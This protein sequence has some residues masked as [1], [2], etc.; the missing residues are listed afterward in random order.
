MNTTALPSALEVEALSTLVN[1]TPI[2]SSSYE[3]NIERQQRMGN[4]Y[5]CVVCGKDSDFK[6]AVNCVEGDTVEIIAKRFDNLSGTSLAAGH[7]GF[8]PV[9][10]SCVKALKKFLGDKADDYIQ[11]EL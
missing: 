7:M 8:Y 1:I 4:G 2:L 5:P 3:K 6:Y 10:S 9:G 11:V